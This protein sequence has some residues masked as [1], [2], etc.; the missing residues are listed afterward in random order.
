MLLDE[1]SAGRERGSGGPGCRRRLGEGERGDLGEASREWAGV[2][3]YAC[4][5]RDVTSTDVDRRLS[6]YSGHHP[7]PNMSD[8]VSKQDASSGVR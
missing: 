4:T 2:R 1:K 7:A 3:E 8:N 6:T 5:H